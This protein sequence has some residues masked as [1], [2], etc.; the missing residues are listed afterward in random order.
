MDYI[1]FAA[2][3]A[4][5]LV[6]IGY[7]SYWLYISQYRRQWQSKQWLA[8]IK[9]HSSEKM[10]PEEENLALLKSSPDDYF[11]SKIPKIFTLETWIQHAGLE[12]SPPVFVA[13]S[14]FIG[15]FLAAVVFI[16]LNANMLSS[17]L[18][19]ISSSLF[20]P[21][22]F[23]TFLAYQRKKKFLEDFPV[24]LDI[25]RRAL[26]A[27]HSMERALNIVAEQQSGVVGETFSRILDMLRLGKP[28]EEVL[29]EISNR[30]GIDDFRLLA[31][32]IV[33]QRETGGS[34]AEAIGNFSKVI[35]ARQILRK[36]VKALTSEVRATALIL[37]GIPFFIFAAVYLTTPGYFDPLFHTDAG[38][39]ILLLG[40]SM[41]V[42][43]II[44][45]FRMSYREYY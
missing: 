24:A 32:V 1:D 29:T 13:I 11:K 35:R 18:L 39:K 21:W 8:R 4:A 20:L 30:V 15:L 26:R 33:L 16:F 5:G 12:I 19:G 34:L 2:I 6:L 42:L 22:V 28:F 9:E 43:G 38:Q 37:I 31:I 41:L 44:I 7:G 36:R 17:V 25:M 45:I 27:G 10:S 14:F 23:V 40:I 3:G